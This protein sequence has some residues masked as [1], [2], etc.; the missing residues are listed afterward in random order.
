MKGHIFIQQ[1]KLSNVRGRINYISS[2][3]KQE[4]LYAVYETNPNPFWKELA[5]ESQEDFKRSGTQG[6]C[7]EARELIIALPQSLYH[8]DHN[9]L[10]K[11]FVDH[12]KQTYG[13]ECSAALHHNKRRTN[14]HIHLIYSERK[15]L[16]EPVIKTASRNRY[17]DESGNHVRTKKEITD[18]S[19]N[20]RE[21]CK[22]IA[23][24][25][26]YEQHLF[27]RKIT[28]F[29]NKNFLDE[30][31]HD[32]AELINSMVSDREKLKVFDKDSPFI[33]TSKVGKNN[34]KAKEIRENNKAKDVWNAEVNKALNNGMPVE[35]LKEIKKE[36]I[37]KP[38][39]ESIAKA[40]EIGLPK[41]SKENYETF[42][43]VVL[44]GSKTL[45]RMLRELFHLPDGE[46]LEAI[47]TRLHEFI[48]FCRVPD[49][50]YKLEKDR[51]R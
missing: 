26:I 44:R 50:R 9:A 30:V 5:H 24:G 13:V 42:R 23:K 22:V 7:I 12:F 19:G 15:L 33:A 37:V 39:A 28:K 40:N 46:R 38:I 27:D 47:T 10:L 3:A 1:S 20:L 6:S 18:E 31:K 29:K 49:K 51:E 41:E 14:F 8:E 36:E 48:D 45:G 4:Y 34:P 35:A 43:S 16:E 11:V 25:E 21:G 2:H 32:Y 17:Y